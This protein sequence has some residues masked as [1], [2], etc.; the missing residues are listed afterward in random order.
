M[1]S[2]SPVCFY[3]REQRQRTMLRHH[4]IEQLPLLRLPYRERLQGES[5]RME[6]ALY[7]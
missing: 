4:P 7:Q 6:V 3:H 5:T 1:H 2:R